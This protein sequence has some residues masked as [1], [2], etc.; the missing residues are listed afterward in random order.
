MCK[1]N[2]IW[3][4]LVSQLLFAMGTAGMCP[5]HFFLV[6]AMANFAPPLNEGFVL[7]ITNVAHGR[8]VSNPAQ[9]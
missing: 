8:E 1:Q 3:I 5:P 4:L 6:V 7:E 2:H 9:Q